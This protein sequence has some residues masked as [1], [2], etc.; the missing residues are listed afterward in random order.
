MVSIANLKYTS[1]HHDVHLLNY[2]PIQSKIEHKEEHAFGG[3]PCDWTVVTDTYI[4][5]H[6]TPPS[7][8]TQFPFTGCNKPRWQRQIWD[9][10]VHKPMSGIALSMIT[11]N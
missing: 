8:Y 10:A 4:R 3:Q 6:V 2:G 1:I 9:M 7:Q 5:R 11:S